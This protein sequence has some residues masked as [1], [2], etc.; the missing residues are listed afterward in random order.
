MQV[1]H[2]L[3]EFGPG[4]QREFV[5]RQRASTLHDRVALVVVGTL[6]VVGMLTIFYALLRFDTATKGYYTRRLIVGVPLA[7]M[8]FVVLMLALAI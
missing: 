5:D 4:I 8:A 1:A 3:L 2:L 7:I 6:L